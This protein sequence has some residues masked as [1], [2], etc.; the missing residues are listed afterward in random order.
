MCSCLFHSSFSC[1]Y[2]LPLHLKTRD[3]TT[4][5]REKFAGTAK[6]NLDELEDE[7]LLSMIRISWNVILTEEDMSEG[8]N[9]VE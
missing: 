8:H 7:P 3:M 9:L 4:V 5:H 1:R 2:S 6:E